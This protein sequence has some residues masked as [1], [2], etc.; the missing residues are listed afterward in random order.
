MPRYQLAYPFRADHDAQDETKYD[1]D[2]MLTS[3]MHP[4]ENRLI[5]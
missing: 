5:K 4:L 3:H 2:D 1:A